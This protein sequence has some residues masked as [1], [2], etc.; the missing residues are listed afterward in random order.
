MVEAYTNILRY[1]DLVDKVPGYQELPIIIPQG[2]QGEDSEG[3]G[4]GTAV[5]WGDEVKDSADADAD[6]AGAF[7]GTSAKSVAAGATAAAAAEEE[8]KFKE[9]ETIETE[10]VSAEK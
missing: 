8:E 2:N 1:F 5:S 7:A 9:K 10:E 4:W 3:E 6:A